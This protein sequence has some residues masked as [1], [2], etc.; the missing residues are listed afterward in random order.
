MKP[1]MSTLRLL[2]T[3]MITNSQFSSAFYPTKSATLP[4]RTVIAGLFNVHDFGQDSNGKCG[5][6][7]TAAVQALEAVRWVFKRLNQEGY[8]PGNIGNIQQN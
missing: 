5:K 8:L 6:V 1:G 3:L 7:S 4:G 2:V